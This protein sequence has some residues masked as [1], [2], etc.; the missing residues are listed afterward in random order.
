[1][2]ADVIKGLL[3]P[4]DIKHVSCMI[5]LLSN[6]YKSQKLD[7]KEEECR[8]FKVASYEDNYKQAIRLVLV[9]RSI[10]ASVAPLFAS[11]TNKN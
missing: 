8:C 11:S 1:M 9:K 6:S 10:N 4:W 3:E 5:K 7:K 2:Q